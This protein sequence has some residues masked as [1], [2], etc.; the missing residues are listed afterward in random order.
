MNSTLLKLMLANQSITARIL[1]VSGLIGTIGLV[2]ITLLLTRHMEDSLLNQSRQGAERIVSSASHGLQAIML[3]GSANIANG[4]AAGLKNVEGL[5]AFRILKITG[6]EAFQ[7]DTASR[8]LPRHWQDSFDQALDSRAPVS[9]VDEGKGGQRELHF[10]V[11]LLN[12]KPCHT[13][14]DPHQ[15]VRGV[16]LLST[17]LADVDRQLSQANLTAGLLLLVMVTAFVG[18]LWLVVSRALGKPLQVIESGLHAI[19]DGNLVKRIPLDSGSSDEIGRM[20]GDVNTMADKFL[21][22]IRLIFLQTQ[23]LS[24]CVA[25][26]TESKKG[27]AN[28]S[29]ENFVLAKEIVAEHSRVEASAVSIQEGT[30]QAAEGVATITEAVE[31][32]TTNIGTIATNAEQASGNVTTMASA[33]EQIT[34]NIGGVNTSLRQVDASVKSVAISVQKMTGSLEQVRSRC[35]A[36]SAESDQAAQQAHDTREMMERLARSAQEIGK[37]IEL[38]NDIAEQTN[39]LSLNASIEAAGAGEAGKGFAV[40]A[41]EV[42]ELARQTAEATRMIGERVE[43]IQTNSREVEEA[44]ATIVSRIQQI[45][46]GNLEI[47]FAV[48]EQTRAINGISTAINEVAEAAS[49]VTRNA[50]ELNLA[51]SD[52]ARSALEAANGTTEIATSSANAS[53]ASE[54]V[55]QQI[56]AINQLARDLSDQARE[57]AEATHNADEKLQRTFRNISLI[58]GAINHTARLIDTTA[59]PGKRLGESVKA[60]TVGPP[61]FDVAVI[62]GAHL[63]WLGRLENVIRGRARL[64]PEE[65][66][67]GHEC[68]FGKWYDT[69]GTANY[70]H[71]PLFKQVG[72]VHMGVHE[73]A[74]ECVTLVAEG[75]TVEAVKKMDR[76]SEIKD[77]LFDLLDQLYLETFQLQADRLLQAAREQ[78]KSSS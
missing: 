78:Q 35:Q 74:R 4:Y 49:E 38:I 64:R 48:D 27:L 42:K 52:V 50:Q 40:V 37:V 60:F 58:D 25:E 66:A 54:A 10:I 47:T 12:Q 16:F 29:Q 32:L 70:G 73:T 71:L 57:V 17:S 53:L 20:A 26:L 63:K 34:A 61:P 31:T 22:V 2:T 21:G 75:N 14:H 3:A 41:N 72:V 5:K 43:E 1:M 8:A 45:N 23:S 39:M 19:A 24:S 56:R 46:Q 15:P 13:C 59:I 11:P 6:Q 77:E 62:K 28:D 69:D 18:L 76:F 51:A 67:S 44:N 7:G 68:D 36:T 55:A 65:V 33:A 9:F 30:I